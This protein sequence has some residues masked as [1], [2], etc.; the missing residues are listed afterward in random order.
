RDNTFTINGY[1]QISSGQYLF[2]LLNFV[3]KPFK[4]KKG[5]RIIWTGD[6]LNADINVNATYEGLN[7]SPA[8]LLD[9]LSITDERVK[10]R[11]RVDLTMN[12]RGSLLKPDINFKLSF[13]DISGGLRNLLEPKLRYLEQNPEQM[14]QQ[15]ATL[16]LFRTFIGTSSNIG[17][18][19][20]VRSTGINTISE[21]LSNQVSI[22]VSNLLSEAF[23]KV[24]FISGVDF[25]VNYDANKTVYGTQQ[26]NASELAVNLKQRLLNDQ[27]SFSFG[28]NYGNSSAINPNNSYFNPESIIEWNTPVAG[29]K[30]KIYYRGV[31][32]IDGVRRRVGTGVSYR[33]E[34]N[35]LKDLKKGLKEQ[36]IKNAKNDEEKPN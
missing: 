7:I 15:V 27:L 2:T 34:F 10:E 19:S 8:P 23:G 3:N 33:K 20:S 21:F 1:Y 5:G 16:I 13:P 30:M 31:D 26:T 25:N 4:L 9:E 12:M 14:N 18:L 35:S 24:D 6:P 29:L 28:G 17:L 22:F 11:T 36:Q 32:G